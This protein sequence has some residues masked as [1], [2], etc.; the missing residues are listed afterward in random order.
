M[1][2]NT[3]SNATAGPVAC[4]HNVHRVTV[5]GGA[6]IDPEEEDFNDMWNELAERTAIQVYPSNV[7]DWQTHAHVPVKPGARR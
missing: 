7:R 5:G 1:G 6:W 3:S 4:F 2:V